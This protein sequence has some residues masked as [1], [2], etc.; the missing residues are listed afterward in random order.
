MS[1]FAKIRELLSPAQR[2]SA[3]I[4][5]G[6][7][8]IGMALE[9]LGIGLIIPIIALLTQADPTSHPV[10]R[11]V[12]ELLGNPSRRSLIVDAMLAL[13]AIYVLKN[14][15]LTFLAWWQTRFAFGIEIDLSQR[16]FTIYLRQPYTFHLQRNSSE[17][18]Q[19]IGSEV[20]LFTAAISNA[21]LL[22]TETLV[23]IGIGLLLLSVQPVGALLVVLVLGGAAVLFHRATRHQIS[24]WGELRYFH[25]ERSVQHLMQGLGGAKD[26]KL[27]GRETEFINQFNIHNTEGARVGQLMVTL[28]SMPRLGLE[29]LMVAGLTTLVLS[30]LAQGAEVRT[31]VPTLGLFAAA[32]FRLTPSVN[33]VLLAVQSLRY[34]IVVLDTLRVEFSLPAPEPVARTDSETARFRD[35]VRLQGVTYTYANA[36]AP[37]LV[38][39]S[40]RIGCGECVGFIGPSGSGKSTMVDVILGLLTP[41]HGR[42]MVDDRDIQLDPRSWQDQIGYVPQ[43]IYLT[44]DTLR[45]NVAFGLGD[46]QIDDD[47]VRHALAAAQLSEF[48]A[49]L[50]DGV[51]TFVGERGIR[52]S[53]GQRQR[54]GIARALYHDPA[55]LVLDE[56]TSSLDIAA[57]QSVM[58]AVNKLQGTKTILIVAHRLST[59]ENC[60]RLYRLEAGRVVAEGKPTEL[61]KRFTLFEPVVP[62]VDRG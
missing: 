32:A 52:L 45:R 28:Q 12:V 58:Q 55:V 49:S 20:G 2:G 42:V 15:F 43:M 27:L 47:A 30:M 23:L 31:I 8:L 35:S 37:A 50:P 33:R 57:E 16:L 21:I 13:T 48:V 14:L 62:Q 46:D 60:E 44:D 56:A 7:M 61:L 1:T 40:V 51:E 39:V 6:F 4:L 59:V 24:R 36:P 18:F 53:G 9:T 54:I 11:T 26:V 25:A 19:N 38:D 3:L 10:G 29:L 34:Q 5:F 22:V 41:E 17:L